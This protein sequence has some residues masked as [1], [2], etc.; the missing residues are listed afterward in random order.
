MNTLLHGML[1]DS[2]QTGL[3]VQ[4]SRITNVTVSTTS[5]LAGTLT[6]GGNG[7]PFT[8]SAGL[9]GV[10]ETGIDLFGPVYFSLSDALD[11]GKATVSWKPV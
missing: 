7:D 1:L 4:V 5:A 8:T 6:L 3:L 10:E 9:N 11:L 2:L